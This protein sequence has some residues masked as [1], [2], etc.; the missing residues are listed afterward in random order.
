MIRAT[1]NGVLRSYRKNLMGSFITL[2]RTR[3][4]V[5]SQRVFESY[6]ED[7]AAASQAFQLRRSYLRSGS[8]ITNSSS[9]IR[10]YE[11][12]YNSLESVVNMVDNRTE[13]SAWSSVLSALNDPTGDSRTALG[14]QLDQLANS[15]VQTMNTQYG[16][17]FTFAG[18]DGLNVPF[19]WETGADGTKQLFYRGVS[20]NATV[21]DLVVSGGAPLTVN[22]N[23]EY[24]QAGDHYFIDGTVSTISKTEYN[25]MV[26]TDRP[27]VL[28]AGNTLQEVDAKGNLAAGGGYY[29]VT[30]DAKTI[31]KA[32]YDQAV[33]D[34]AKLEFMSSE[35]NYVDIGLGF[36]EDEQGRLISSSGFNMALQGINFL[37]YGMDEDG[38]PKNIVSL[39]REMSNICSAYNNGE[40]NQDVGAYR[41]LDRLAGKLETA[42]KQLQVMHTDMSA[43][44]TFLKDNHAQLEAEQYTLTEQIS[45]LEDVDLADAITAFSWAQYCYN[46][47]LKVGNSILSQSLM[48]Y[49]N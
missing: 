36:Q 26:A 6:G 25:A 49:M 28:A 4:T 16:D 9:V 5:L 41:D 46:A 42:S 32:D 2:N 13:N 3:D 8:Q 27:K 24:D 31:S 15:I 35:A 18:A 45:Q 23:G 17:T 47:A 38:D 7:P 48:D 20:V 11:T 39:L 14:K 1:T 43:E 22:A 34:V 12:A 21:P 44:A 33:E 10:K 37:G 40:W 29:L 19:T 30:T